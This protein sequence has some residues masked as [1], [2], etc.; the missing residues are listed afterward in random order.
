MSILFNK[1]FT[2]DLPL[3][4]SVQ[5]ANL[6]FLNMMKHYF[7]EFHDLSNSVKVDY[8]IYYLFNHT[9]GT[10]IKLLVGSMP[11][12]YAFVAYFDRDG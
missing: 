1:T 10:V 8:N 9:Y 7:N 11:L 6:Y 12:G 4:Q 2:G 5:F 3:L